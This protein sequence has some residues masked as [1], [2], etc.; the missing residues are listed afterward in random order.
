M[1]LYLSSRFYMKHLDDEI[2]PL[3]KFRLSTKDPDLIKNTSTNLNLPMTL[4][5]LI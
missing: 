1:P 5:A 2:M 4:M 3:I